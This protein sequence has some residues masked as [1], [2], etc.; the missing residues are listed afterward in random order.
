[1][2]E[3]TPGDKVR[4]KATDN[5]PVMVLDSFSEVTGSANC[6]CVWFNKDGIFQSINVAKISLEK[7]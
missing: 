1:M 3:I 2:S 6:T 7:V 5:A 4:L